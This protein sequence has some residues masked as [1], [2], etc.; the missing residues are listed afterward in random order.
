[1]PAKLIIID[2]YDSFTYNLFQLFCGCGAEVRVFRHDEVGVSEIEALRPDAICISPGPRDPAHSGISP[3]LVRFFAG[4]VPIMGV[5]LGMQVINEVYGGKTI[6]APVPVHGKVSPI[7]HIAQGIF[8]GIP[9]P[10]RAA[11]YHSL[12]IKRLSNE[13]VEVAWSNDNVIMA[14]EH[15]RFP[16]FGVQFHPES[17]LTEYGKKLAMNFLA[18]C[19]CGVREG[20]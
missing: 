9:S 7:R 15:R 10:F 17:F 16:V 11:R 3:D 12:C 8:H 20:G 19:N 13:L 18:I 14:V 5:C 2:N 6:Y 4:R 1:M